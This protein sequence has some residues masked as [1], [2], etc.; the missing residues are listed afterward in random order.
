MH[1]FIKNLVTP[2]PGLKTASALKGLVDDSSTTSFV[3]SKVSSDSACSWLTSATPDTRSG[4][5]DR[6]GL[7]FLEDRMMDIITGRVPP[8][9]RA[10]S[11]RSKGSR[12]H[13]DSRR[14][15]IRL[16]GLE[17]SGLKKAKRCRTIL[18]TRPR[19]SSSP[20]L[21]SGVADV[22]QLQAE[23]DET[24]DRTKIVVELSSTNPNKA[25]AVFKP[26]SGVGCRRCQPAAGRVGRDL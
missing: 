18:I 17:R 25:E 10:E 6:L 23:S 5:E 11:H 12:E 22:N 26:G 19:R 2:D 9:A 14:E 13:G 20:D 21:V 16:Y 7:G 1:F 24:F 8:P 3:L 4:L 15:L